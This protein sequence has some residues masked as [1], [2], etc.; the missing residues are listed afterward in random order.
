MA[1]GSSV[2]LRMA[3]QATPRRRIC[4]NTLSIALRNYKAMQWKADSLLEYF[5]DD[6]KDF[7][8][9]DFKG[10]EKELAESA[11]GLST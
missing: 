3:C 9:N 5:C 8:V 4:K 1:S 11:T 7:T 2:N 10:L 6:F